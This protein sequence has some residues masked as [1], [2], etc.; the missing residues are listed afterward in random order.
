MELWEKIGRQRVQYIVESYQLYGDEIVDFNDYLTDLLQAYMPPQIELA[1][2]ETIA[3]TW[4]DIPMLRGIPFIKKVHEL[5]RTWE[6]PANFKTLVS[7]DQF[8]QIT[9]LDPAPV[10]GND[11]NSL[12]APE[13]K[14]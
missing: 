12:P 11:Y 2:V 4:S 1:L 3:Q 14:S 5:L 10:F 7:P 6:D 9:N 8:F 13:S